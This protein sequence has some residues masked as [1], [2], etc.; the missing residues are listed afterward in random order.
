MAL[1]REPCSDATKT[2]KTPT[3]ELLRQWIKTMAKTSQD[4]TVKGLKKKA[5]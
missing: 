1:G 4:V 3:E 2:I 5:V